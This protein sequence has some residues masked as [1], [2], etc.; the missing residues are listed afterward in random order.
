M[1]LL[2]ASERQRLDD[3]GY[4][5][6][7]GIVPPEPVKAMRDRLEELLLVTEQEHRGTLIVHRE[8]RS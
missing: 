4:L 3:D 2:T 6:L 1:G 8:I 7:E 5:V